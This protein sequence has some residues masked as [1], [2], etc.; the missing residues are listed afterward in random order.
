MAYLHCV[1]YRTDL[2]GEWEMAYYNLYSSVALQEQYADSGLV[3]WREKCAVKMC[4]ALE[5]KHPSYQFRVCL[6]E[7]D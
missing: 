1:E 6:R 5:Q 4:Q 2:G 7:L 3:Y